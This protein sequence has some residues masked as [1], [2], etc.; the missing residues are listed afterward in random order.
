MSILYIAG[1]KCSASC[2]KCRSNNLWLSEVW[3]DNGIYFQIKDGVFP[4]EASDHFQ[5][6]P[7]YVTAMCSDCKHEWR[8]RKGVTSIW[9]LVVDE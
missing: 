2:P 7:V 8:I 4:D 1:K 9:D 3:H 5:G 6:A